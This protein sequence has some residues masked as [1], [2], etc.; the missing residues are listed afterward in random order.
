[1]VQEST[2]EALDRDTT[3][4]IL[5]AK[6]V[7]LLKHNQITPWSPA[8]VRATSTIIIIKYW[9]LQIKRGIRDRSDTLL[10]YYLSQSD[11]EADFDVSLHLRECIHQIN[12]ARSKLKDVVANAMEL[13]SQFEADLAIPIVEH[14]RPEFHDGETYME[15]DKDVLVQ[16]EIKS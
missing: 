3:R 5:H 4:A 12:N 16:K 10:D 7:C 1:M 8:I 14:K 15:C 9:D 13:R 2:Y 6:S 11:V